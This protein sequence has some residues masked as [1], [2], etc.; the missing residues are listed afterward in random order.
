MQLRDNG[1]IG[2]AGGIGQTA[3]GEGQGGVQVDEAGCLIKRVW[4][5]SREVILAEFTVISTK[6][7]MRAQ[8]HSVNMVKRGVERR[9][10]GK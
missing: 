9:K 3:W 1:N 6:K 4:D 7:D 2:G 5:A 8:Q 10:D